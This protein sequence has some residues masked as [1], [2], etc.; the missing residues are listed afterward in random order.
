[1]PIRTSKALFFWATYLQHNLGRILQS[2]ITYWYSLLVDGGDRLAPRGQSRSKLYEN[3]LE[4]SGRHFY[5]AH[6]KELHFL[7]SYQ[8]EKKCSW[9]KS[10]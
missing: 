5:Q 9:R 10:T 7:T 8:F 4:E 1:M 3:G 6:I 2:R